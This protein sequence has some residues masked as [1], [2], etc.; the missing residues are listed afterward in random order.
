MLTIG[1]HLFLWGV[2]FLTGITLG[3]IL[4]SL[5]MQAGRKLRY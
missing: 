3:F 1:D 2:F 4:A 5:V